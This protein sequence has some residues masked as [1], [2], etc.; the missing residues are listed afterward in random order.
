M[1]L[2]IGLVAGPASPAWAEGLRSAVVS[3]ALWSDGSVFRSEA[4]GAARVVADRYGHGG[5]VIVRANTRKSFAAGPRGMVQAMAR[6]E[7][8]MDT[9]HDVL[10]LILSSHGAPQGIAEKGGRIAG[11]LAPE[12]LGAILRHSAYRHKVLIV[13]ACYAGI[14]TTLANDTTLVLTAADAT[15]PSFGCEEGRT[16]TYFGDAFFNTALRQAGP[17]P[18]RFEAAKALIRSREEAQGFDPSNPQIAGGAAVLPL[19]DGE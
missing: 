19:L 5:P 14:F 3:L 16:W 9:A 18:E 8:G 2:L 17:L 1:L 10:F 11:L 7:R 6:A 13:S 4:N 12:A 15:H